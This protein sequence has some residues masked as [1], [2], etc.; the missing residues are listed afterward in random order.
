MPDANLVKRT[1]AAGKLKPHLRLGRAALAKLVGKRSC[2]MLV[3]RIDMG[4]PSAVLHAGVPRVF[5]K[6]ITLKRALVGHHK[7]H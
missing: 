6:R 2:V 4:L 7:K 3:V 5:V 1:V